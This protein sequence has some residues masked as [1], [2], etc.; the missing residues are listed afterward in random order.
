MLGLEASLLGVD[1]VRGGRQIGKDMSER[2]LLEQMADAACSLIL[3]PV[4][5]QGFLLG[6]G[7][8]QISPAVIRRVGK[9]N[10]IVVAT[11]E[12]LTSL[13]GRPLLVD[14]GD[15]ET[16]LYLCSYYRVVTGY[17][18]AAVYRVSCYT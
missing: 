3:T 18:E 10:I 7:N 5:G 12:K 6:R 9:E 14:T 1:M 4:G 15:V 2:E 8:Q 13:R 16:D 17:R 11:P